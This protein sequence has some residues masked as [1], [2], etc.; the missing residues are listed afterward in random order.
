[1]HWQVP[2][3]IFPVTSHTVTIIPYTQNPAVEINAGTQKYAYYWR[4]DLY[5]DPAHH[6]GHQ[7]Q[8]TFLLHHNEQLRQHTTTTL[9]SPFFVKTLRSSFCLHLTWE[10]IV[11]ALDTAAAVKSACGS[12]SVAYVFNSGWFCW[13]TWTGGV[14]YTLVVL[15][16]LLRFIHRWSLSYMR[17]SYDIKR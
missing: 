7:C 17:Q 8:Y 14:K 5:C 3:M 9:P 6:A 10:K 16:R 12:V 2:K 4:S 11:S 1:M 13:I 15:G